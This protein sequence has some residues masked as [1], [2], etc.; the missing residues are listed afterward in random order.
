KIAPIYAREIPEVKEGKQWISFVRRKV[1][2][3]YY[4]FNYSEIVSMMKEKGIGRPSTYAKILEIL[5][6]REYVKEINKRLVSTLLGAR[7]YFFLR[8]KYGKYLNEELTKILEERMDKIEKGEAKA[9]EVIKEFFTE[10][11]EIMKNAMKK[12]VRYNIN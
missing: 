11:N 6:K 12:G 10:V 5:K 2:Q 3:A 9:Q 8:E 7:V 1:V 4:P